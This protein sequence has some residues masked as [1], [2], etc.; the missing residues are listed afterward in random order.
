MGRGDDDDRGGEE[1]SESGSHGWTGLRFSIIRICA[2][3]GV[4]YE[5]DFQIF[6]K[7]NHAS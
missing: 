4:L 5:L 3:Y 1:D 6:I 2:F 7:F